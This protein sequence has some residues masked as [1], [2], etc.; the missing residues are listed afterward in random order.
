MPRI[1]KARQKTDKLIPQMN[2]CPMWDWNPRLSVQLSGAL[3]TMP[4]SYKYIR[5]IQNIRVFNSVKT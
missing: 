5:Q 1:E 2:V 4:P 3:T